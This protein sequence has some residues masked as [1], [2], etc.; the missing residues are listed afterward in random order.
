MRNKISARNFRVRRKEYITTLEEQVAEQHREMQ[1]LRMALLRIQEDNVTLRSEVETLKAKNTSTS[2]ITSAAPA[3]NAPPTP[4]STSSTP[5]SPS[6]KKLTSKDLAKPNL[7]K[8]RSISGASVGWKM[9]GHSPFMSVH[10]T[11]VPDISLSEKQLYEKPCLDEKPPAKTNALVLLSMA[12]ELGFSSDAMAWLAY[13]T[14]SWFATLYQGFE[15]EDEEHVTCGWNA[16]QELLR[17]EAERK[18]KASLREMVW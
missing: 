10:T 1:M 12:S 7:N 18:Q 2:S 3:V 16:E 8:D 13:S 9:G 11:L 15:D 4:A 6:M 5:A 17:E 14:M